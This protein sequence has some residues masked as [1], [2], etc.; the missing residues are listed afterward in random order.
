MGKKLIRSSQYRA[1][2]VAAKPGRHYESAKADDAEYHLF[3]EQ[4]ADIYNA[5]RHAWVLVRRPRPHVIVIEGLKRPSASRSPTE[6]AKYC[7]LF[8]RPWTLLSGKTHVPN[9]ALLGLSLSNRK[10][11]Y[12]TC[13]QLQPKAD[14]C[15]RAVQANTIVT[16]V[17]WHDVWQEYVRGGESLDRF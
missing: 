11:V 2:K 13:T 8:F 16:Q 5:L 15:S 14:K 6:N 1:G 3:P 9:L 12:E 17:Q 4:P 7:S 10:T